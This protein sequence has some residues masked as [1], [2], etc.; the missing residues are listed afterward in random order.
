[1]P[2]E[3]ANVAL[4]RQNE[5]FDRVNNNDP[6]NSVLEIHLWE[7]VETDANLRDADTIAAVAA[8][9]LTEST[10]TG[11]AS[12]VLTDADIGASVVDDGADTRSADIA[13]QTF[14][15]IGPGT[16]ITRLTIGYDADST[17]GTDANIELAAFYDFVVTPNGGHVTAQVNAGGIWSSTQA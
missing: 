17:G 3:V 11:Y 8:L 12:L 10:A 14:P 9:A 15:N 13:D 5:L 6:A 16:G 7:G 2:N 1:M 4:G